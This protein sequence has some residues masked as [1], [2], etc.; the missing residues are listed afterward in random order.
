MSEEAIK[1]KLNKA[2][3]AVCRILKSADYSFEK[4]S[5]NIYCIDAAR[6]T[7]YRKIAIGIAEIK[8]CLWFKTQ[9]KQL[10]EYP[11]PAP[12]VTSK[13]VWIREGGEHDFRVYY[14]KKNTWIDKQ[15]N[16]LFQN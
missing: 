4:T 10:A 11:N 9:V 6:D 2:K 5:N 16:R 12:E 3:N 1:K 15:G 13:E 7:E 8:N 14:L